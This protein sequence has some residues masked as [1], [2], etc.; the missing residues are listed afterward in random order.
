M[1]IYKP[2]YMSI[3]YYIFN[4]ICNLLYN[5][6]VFEI[7]MGANKLD[8]SSDLKGSDI[9]QVIIMHTIVYI[10]AWYLWYESA[11]IVSNIYYS[12]ML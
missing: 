3:F 12:F 9:S 8:M 5:S 2:K 4:S 11:G 7:T 1:S 6:N 10:Y